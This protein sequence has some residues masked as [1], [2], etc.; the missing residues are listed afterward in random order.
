MTANQE[1]NTTVDGVRAIELGYRPILKTD[2]G[3]TVDFQSRIR[4]NAPEM[5]VIL[6]ERFMPVLENSDRCVPLLLL[7]LT[8][9]I[10]AEEKFENRDIYFD[11]ISIPIP[12]RMLFKSDCADKL[13]DLTK[14]LNASPDRVCLEIPSRIIEENGGEKSLSALRKAGFHTMLSKVDAERFPL[15]KLAEL[16]PEYV[17][18]DKR[19]TA[20]ILSGERAE[21]CIK[22]V[23]SFISEIGGKTVASGVTSP[24]AVDK[25]YDLGCSFYIADESMGRVGNFSLE[26]YVRKQDD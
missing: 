12:L 15:Y 24:E 22:S 4:L 26:R 6:Q 16:E 11:W 19:V 25:L 20:G 3:N 13:T 1:Y 23:I 21:T 18:M 9:L 2:T 17:I 5:G 14:Q 10:K 7:A 8:Q